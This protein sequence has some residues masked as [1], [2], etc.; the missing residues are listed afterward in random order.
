MEG[1]IR[2]FGDICFCHLTSALDDMQGSLFEGLS[3]SETAFVLQ[4]D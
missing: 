1:R 4:P 3:K 2:I